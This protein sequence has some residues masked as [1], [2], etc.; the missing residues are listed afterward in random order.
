VVC[1]AVR[2][3]RQG[4][5]E[6]REEE[7]SGVDSKLE[8]MTDDDPATGTSASSGAAAASAGPAQDYKECVSVLDQAF[9]YLTWAC[10]DRRRSPSRSL[11]TS[12]PCLRIPQNHQNSQ[13]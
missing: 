10:E 13:K 8:S 12:L 6:K 4:E 5:R 3:S 1:Q 11:P 2:I 9:L 7:G